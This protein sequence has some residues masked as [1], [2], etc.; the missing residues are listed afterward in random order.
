MST[1][2]LSGGPDAPNSGPFVSRLHWACLAAALQLSVSTLAGSAVVQVRPDARA[3]ERG[4]IAK[5]LRVLV[6]VLEV[7]PQERT[8]ELWAAL[9]QE[10]LEMLPYRRKPVADEDTRELISAYT[11]G[12]VQALAQSSDPSVIP[13]LIQYSTASMHA[14]NR[15][16]TF[17]ERALPLL[18]RAAM[19]TENDLN[20]K[21]GAASALAEMLR[22]PASD[23]IAPLSGDSRRHIA[24]FAEQLLVQGSPLKSDEIV[25]LADVALATGRPDLRQEVERLATDAQAWKQ[26]GVTTPFSIDLG[27]RVIQSI[28]KKS[29]P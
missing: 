26:H 22:R 19:G 29:V 3:L 12:L 27:Q 8:P 4:P 18:L 7:P 13:V 28:L 2:V 25:N 16:A 21:G 23:L 6:D 14:T 24:T 15:L 17:G 10:A 11:A 5:R 20:Q 9:K 1:G